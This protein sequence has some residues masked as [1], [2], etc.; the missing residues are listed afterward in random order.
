[1]HIPILMVLFR[2][3][4]EFGWSARVIF[5]WSRKFMNF[6]VLNT[7]FVTLIPKKEGVMR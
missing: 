4:L 1:M 2:R 7:T 6:G 5:G 3:K